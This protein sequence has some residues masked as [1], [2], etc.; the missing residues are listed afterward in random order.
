MTSHRSA[1]AGSTLASWVEARESVEEIADGAPGRDVGREGGVE[2]ARIVV[3]ARVDDLMTRW[4]ATGTA[5]DESRALRQDRAVVACLPLT[6]AKWRENLPDPAVKRQ[7][8]LRSSSLIAESHQ[9]DRCARRRLSRA[10]ASRFPRS[11]VT[12]DK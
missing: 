1:R 6:L 5:S 2:R 11:D 9:D 4:G 7:S 10:G 3:I 12:W 8:V